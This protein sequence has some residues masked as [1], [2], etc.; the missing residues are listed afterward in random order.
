MRFICQ[1]YGVR[2][3]KDAI[4]RDIIAQL[5]EAGIGIASGTYEIVGMPKLQVDLKDAIRRVEPQPG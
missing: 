4:S 3:L 1:T 2:E 5:D